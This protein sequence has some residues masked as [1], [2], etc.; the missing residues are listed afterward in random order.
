MKM[1]QTLMLVVVLLLT[2]LLAACGGGAEPTAVPPT[3]PEPAAESVSE[4]A[5]T[6]VRTFVVVPEESQ[7]SYIVDEEFL[8]EALSKLGIEAGKTVVVG[9]TP[10][11]SGE[12][13]LNLEGAEP[14]ESAQFSVDM[15]G[16]QTDQD[17]RDNWLKDNA[18][19]TS[20]FPA[21]TFT[22]TSVTGLP[23]SIN[24]GE[25]I[26]FELTGD[27][28]VRDVTKSVT[29]AVTAV[30]QGDTLEGTAVLPL[31]IS[32]FGIAPPDFANTLTVADEFRIE[33]V[34]TACES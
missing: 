5:P 28:T 7:A 11:V 6:G 20:R 27:L 8:S 34:L 29:F 21:A 25:E 30:L 2:G 26:S 16:L 31:K 12:I 1:K 15:T 23:E 3:A 13:Q 32:D 24:E 22:A 18:I 9:T 17:R 19:E 14:V 4:A 10:G 33:V